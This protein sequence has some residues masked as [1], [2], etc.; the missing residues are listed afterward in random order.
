MCWYELTV[1]FCVTSTGRGPIIGTL[2]GVS[3]LPGSMPTTDINQASIYFGLAKLLSQRPE[4][5]PPTKEKLAKVLKIVSL[6]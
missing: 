5:P 3:V 6:L 1:K 2:G 4:L